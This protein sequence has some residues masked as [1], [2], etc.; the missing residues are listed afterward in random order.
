MMNEA[1]IK[2]L[3]EILDPILEADHAELVALE[4]KG[5]T[6]SLIIR[7]Y[8][9]TVDRITLS[10]CEKISRALS[11][12]LDMYDIISGNY[13]LEVSSP[14]VNRPLRSYADFNRNL[15]REVEVTYQ[16]ERGEQQMDGKIVQVAEDGVHIKHNDAVKVIAF[17]NIKHAK[18]RLPW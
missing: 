5:K 3:R 15:N 18:V 8:V 2:N 7:V 10:Q 17:A 13:R 12:R 6:D 14:G 16:D 9:D 4:V 1:L 11:D